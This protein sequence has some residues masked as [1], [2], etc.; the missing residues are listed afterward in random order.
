MTES[1]SAAE[2]TQDPRLRSLTPERLEEITENV[3]GGPRDLTMVELAARAEVPID[4]ART[5]WRGM[6]FR[7]VADDV[8]N[9]GESDVRALRGWATALQTGK[10]DEIT[11]VSLLRAQSYMMDRL[12]LWQ[13]EATVDTHQRRLGL[14]DSEARLRMLEDLDE[15][16]DF[17]ADQITYSWRRHLVDLAERV[18]TEIK[19]RL[20]PVDSDGLP[21]PRALGFVDMVSFTSR[22]RQLG[23]RELA[24]LV[25]GFEFTARDVITANGARV[26]KTVG[27]AVLYIADDVLTGA[28]VGLAM[29][30]AIGAQEHL[31]PVRAS[32]VWGRIVSRSGDVFGP[33]V[34][35]ASRL[36]DIA[37]TDT[38]YTDASTAALLAKSPHAADFLM[39]DQ[40][41]EVLPGIGEVSPVELRWSSPAVRDD[42]WLPGLA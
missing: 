14:D 36:M 15:S 20:A 24:R 37:P 8:P 11:L 16:D 35:L 22:S 33:A 28:R 31:L 19:S 41:A 9:F 18:D 38:L 23:S 7:N 42:V 3:L 17:M 13:V 32:L 5:F 40:I 30:D 10:I 26:V 29:I 25:E 2:P 1:A 27:D 4:F 34:N 12:A 21:L 6:G 39:V